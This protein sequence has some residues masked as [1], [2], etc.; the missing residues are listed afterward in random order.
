[1]FTVE[2]SEK[3]KAAERRGSATRH[4]TMS[5]THKTT[6]ALD[7]PA[8]SVP[9]AWTHS[10]DSEYWNPAGKSRDEAI[11]AGKRRGYRKFWIA[12]CRK[13]TA[14]EQEEYDG[15]WIV[16]LTTHEIITPNKQI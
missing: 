8:G 11:Q 10:P 5:T 12:Q 2:A 1:M 16:D 13:M 15:T 3:L 4:H 9:W 7:V 6:P 14:D